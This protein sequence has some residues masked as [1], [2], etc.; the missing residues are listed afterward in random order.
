[1]ERK[2]DIK[3]ERESIFG[4]KILINETELEVNL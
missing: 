4:R 1:M 2:N 3:R